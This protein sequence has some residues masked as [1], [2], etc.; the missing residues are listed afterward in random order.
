MAGGGRRSVCMRRGAPRPRRCGAGRRCRTVSA[1]SS[2][3]ASGSATAAATVLCTASPGDSTPPPPSPPGRDSRLAPAQA[4]RRHCWPA[5]G[6]L[7]CSSQCG[8]GTV[9]WLINPLNKCKISTLL[10]LVPRC[11]HPFLRCEQVIDGTSLC[12]L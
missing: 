4:S 5:E 8:G 6:A 2:S 3:A 7:L 11:A 12:P 9:Q 10:P 1:C